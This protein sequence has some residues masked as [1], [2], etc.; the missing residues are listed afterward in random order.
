M[1]QL[2]LST[3]EHLLR[4]R[5]TFDLLKREPYCSP[6]H[7]YLATQYARLGYPDLAAGS[8]Y[9]A[10][11]LKDAID[12]P[13]EE[14]HDQANE[15]MQS[16]VESQPD[17]ERKRLQDWQANSESR[18]ED[19]LR[20]QV[21]DMS[22]VQLWM[23]MH[24]APIMYAILTESLILCGCLRTADTYIKQ[25]RRSYPDRVDFRDI[26]ER[27]LTTAEQRMSL[28]R[29]EI[30]NVTA[31][32]PDRGFVRREQYPW[33]EYEPSRLQDVDTLNV[34]MQAVSS[35]LEV[36]VVELPVLSGG[37]ATSIFQ[38]GVFAKEDLAPGQVVLQEKSLLTANNKLQDTLCDACSSDLPELGSE[39]AEAVV[40]CP[41]CE[42]IF[43][44]QWC[45]D[46]ALE[47]YHSALCDKDVEAI[48]KDVPPA[49]AADSLYSLLLLRVLA[50]AETQE[51]HPLSLREVRY[52]WGD[53]TNISIGPDLQQTLTNSDSEGNASVSRPKTLPFSFE[54]NIRLPFHMLEKMDVD[55]FQ[56][57][58]YDVWT[59]NTLYAK[60]RGTASARLSGTGGRAIR[61]PEVSAVHPMWCLANHSCE[62]N[63]TWD[64]GGEVKFSTRDVPIRSRRSDGEERI[65]T[66]GV[67]KGEE[68]LNHYCD[69]DLPV[70]E[71][72]EWAS[73]ALGGDCQCARCVW[74]TASETPSRS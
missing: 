54:H 53:F 16:I 55:I 56:Q 43:C 8:A 67:K 38:L 72:R 68:I 48:A 40:A 9:K 44:S 58:T 23:Y 14:Y 69:I 5:T 24:Y 6:V 49:E 70:R 33:N 35:V 65:S 60:F 15:A 46:N 12:E 18:D 11:L 26:Q 7:I 73:G 64:W 71:R 41:D 22:E 32:W 50:M 61:G 51:C 37:K 45:F 1:S 47:L 62:P 27:L 25:A 39:A 13:S 2:G 19:G 30:L 42:V 66:L 36:R 17:E 4:V 63:V 3:K 31:E 34:W 29:E 28:P 57:V 74:E 20:E 10:L 59:F 52:I 21:A